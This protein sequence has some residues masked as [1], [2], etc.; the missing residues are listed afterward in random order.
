LFRQ[1]ADLSNQLPVPDD[2]SSKP[3]RTSF[4]NH[5]NL[6]S[7]QETLYAGSNNPDFTAYV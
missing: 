6:S 1:K 3:D 4:K 5:K 7:K 2:Y